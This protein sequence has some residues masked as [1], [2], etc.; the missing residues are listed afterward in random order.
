MLDDAA[1]FRDCHGPIGVN[2]DHAGITL[3]LDSL[4]SSQPG[5]PGDW[6]DNVSPLA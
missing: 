1:V 4:C 6:K 5:R 2:P 3:L